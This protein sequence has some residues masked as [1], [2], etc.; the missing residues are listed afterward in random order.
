[1]DISR[2]DTLAYGIMYLPLIC[3]ALLS[4]RRWILWA[5]TSLCLTMTAIGVF[6]PSV[7]PN[8][9]DLIANRILSALAIVATAFLVRY[10]QGMQDRLTAATERAETAER[11]RTE[12]LSNLGREMRTPLHSMIAMLGLLLTQSRP[13]QRPPLGKMRSGAQQLLLTIDNLVDLTQ[14]EERALHPRPID[15]AMILRAAV[16]NACGAAEDN[17]VGLDLDCHLAGSAAEAFIACADSWMTRRILD[18][19][20]FN[21]IRVTQPPRCVSVS[22]RQEARAVV[23]TIGNTRAG[24]AEE[25]E[26]AGTA[27]TTAGIVAS[28]MTPQVGAGLTL[29]MRLADAMG[30][31]LHIQAEPGG[32]TATILF[33][34]RTFE[35]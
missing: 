8:L 25:R 14:I 6:F 13:D 29:G 24:L 31:T 10:A 2:V 21:A 17:G 28:L 33:L 5:L 20:L 18:N 4:R 32:G 9:P 22:I 12:V 11:V 35:I 19:L 23:V 3:T 26:A 15:V 30:G 1:M 7:N 34:P 27:G 16:Q